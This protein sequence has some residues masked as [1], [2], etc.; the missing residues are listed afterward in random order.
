L[1]RAVRELSPA[2]EDDRCL[3]SDIE[4]VNQAVVAGEIGQ[5]LETGAKGD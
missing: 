3:D 2:L 5:G 1:V 4:V